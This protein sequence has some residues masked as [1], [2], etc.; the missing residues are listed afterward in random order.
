M[1]KSTDDI[2]QCSNTSTARTQYCKYLV[3]AVIKKSGEPILF[4][5]NILKGLGMTY[6]IQT[7][8]RTV[9]LSLVLC[10]GMCVSA[11]Y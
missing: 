5:S 2:V 6:S 10:V 1:P 4:L 3:G 11:L 8:R 9:Q 7:H